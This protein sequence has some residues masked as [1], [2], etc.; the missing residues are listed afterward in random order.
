MQ[1]NK[2]KGYFITFEGPDGSGKSTQ[3]KLLYDK[4][5]ELNIPC[6]ITREPGGTILGE[7]MRE[8]LKDPLLNSKLSIQTEALLLQT[9]RAQ[10][11]YELIMPALK[12]GK[13]VL[14]DRYSDSSTAYQGMARGLG[15]DVIESLNSFATSNLKPDLTIILDLSPEEGLKR[16]E[17]RD[18]NEPKDRWEEQKV[19]FHHKV[20]NAFLELAANDPERY[21]VISVQNTIDKT[22]QMILEKVNNE[23]GIL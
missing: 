13:V 12:D 16:A 6:I 7:K 23:L 19:E 21:A 4:L 20:R 1:K 14:C 10:H 17:E 15:K 5:Q 2:D 11:V 18:P 22:R 8:I 3:I 9:S